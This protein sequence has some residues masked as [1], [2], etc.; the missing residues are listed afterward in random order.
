M[1]IF[2]HTQSAKPKIISVSAGELLQ[3]VLIR[4]DILKHGD[5]DV[6][7]FVGECAEAQSEPLDVE[8]GVDQQT[9]TDPS[10]SIDDLQLELHRHVHVHRCRRVAVGVNFLD[11]TKQHRFSPATTIGVVTDWARRKF[12]LDPAT[13]G[14]YVLQVCG[15]S[16]QPR[17]DVHLG[18]MVQ[19]SECA[20]CFDLVK[21]VTPQG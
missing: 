14:E 19:P 2:V 7:I 10:K 21:E 13:S 16:Q 4:E 5:G 9:P 17:P 8:E 6:F 20:V 3:D 1:D 12:Q 15:T 11:K 18:E